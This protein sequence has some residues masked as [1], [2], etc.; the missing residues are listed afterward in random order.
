MLSLAASVESY[1]EHPLA[2]ALVSYAKEHGDPLQSIMGF[3]MLPGKGVQAD[4]DGG[5]V[6]CG[7][8]IG[9]VGL[10]DTLRE[11]AKD[12]IQE[13]KQM[14][15]EAVLLTGD[16]AKTADYFA[17]K[18]GISTVHSELVP[19]QKVM[20]IK[21]LQRAGK[22]ICMIGDGVNDAPALRTAN[23]GVAMGSMGSDIAVEAA[24]IALMGDDISKIPYLK[25]LPM[26]RCVLSNLAL[27]FRWRLT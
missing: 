17:A 27:P 10:S 9:A 4:A 13:L 5:P 20:Q 7:R 25:R 6:L 23:V 3:Q 1:S 12:M 14:H 18:V 24:D 19:E 8:C 26:R 16:H 15:T 11:S 22:R 21:A 2:K